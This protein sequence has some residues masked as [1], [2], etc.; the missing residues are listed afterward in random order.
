MSTI[1]LT[2]ALLLGTMLKLQTQK[3]PDYRL[4]CPL[5]ARQLSQPLHGPQTELHHSLSSEATPGL[6]SLTPGFWF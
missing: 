4:P 6:I 3:N 1:T 5:Y 2:P